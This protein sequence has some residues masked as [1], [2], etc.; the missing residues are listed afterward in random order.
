MSH[1]YKKKKKKKE[2]G[3]KEE[4]KRDGEER[5]GKIAAGLIAKTTQVVCVTYLGS[6]FLPLLSFAHKTAH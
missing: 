2:R 6:L 5:E 4:E 3:E 1:W